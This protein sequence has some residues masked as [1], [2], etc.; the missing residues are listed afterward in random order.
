MQG[1]GKV[2]AGF[3]S[4]AIGRIAD[5]FL[6]ME[7]PRRGLAVSITSPLLDILTQRCLRHACGCAYNSDV[8]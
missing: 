8:K 6:E 4:R 3:L 7:E 5:P 1:G 2:N